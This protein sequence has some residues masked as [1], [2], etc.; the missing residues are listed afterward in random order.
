MGRRKVRHYKSKEYYERVFDDYFDEKRDD[1]IRD[2]MQTLGYTDFEELRNDEYRSKWGL[3]CGWILIY[4][5]D[6]TMYHEWELDNGKYNAY[7][8][9]HPSYYPQSTTLQRIQV[10]K[11]IKDLGLSDMF[12]AV[13]KL[14]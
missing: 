1:V 13:T 3:D 6:K 5:K 10:D 14:D 11:A 8:F 4:P 12:Y 2:L 9:A 7:I